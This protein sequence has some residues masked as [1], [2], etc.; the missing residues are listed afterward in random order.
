LK[1]W[2]G[3]CNKERKESVVR[4]NGLQTSTAPLQPLD[5]ES[6][7]YGVRTAKLCEAEL[8]DDALTAALRHARNDGIRLLVWPATGRRIVCSDLLD[9]YAGMLVDR[10][11][12][13]SKVLQVKDIDL[14][15]SPNDELDVVSYNADAVSPALC[16]LAVAAGVKSRFALDPRIPRERFEAMYRCWIDRSVLRELAD[17]VLVVPLGG[18]PSADARLGGMVTIGVSDGVATIGLV[19]VAADMRGRGIGTTL[20]RAAERWMLK[21]KARQARVVTQLDNTA[22]CRL[23]ERSGF[24]LTLLQHYYHFWL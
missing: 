11:A 13:F 20:M 16:E 24:R 17:V 3:S 12:T 19:A 14:T 21:H 10:K 7:H 23:Y 18:G 22:A 1:A 15:S 2:A 9:E 5:W 8:D 6:N 4:A